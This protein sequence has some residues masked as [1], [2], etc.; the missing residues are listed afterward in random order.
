MGYAVQ[1][2]KEKDAKKYAPVATDDDDDGVE[3]KNNESG[4][5]NKT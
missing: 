1:L 4:G 5:P 3:L 2:R